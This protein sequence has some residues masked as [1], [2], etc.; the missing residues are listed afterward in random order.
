[1]CPI[2]VIFKLCSAE[3]SANKFTAIGILVEI[4]ATL[5]LRGTASDDEYLSTA[6]R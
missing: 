3:K 5:G 4:T 1:M 2:V 6:V